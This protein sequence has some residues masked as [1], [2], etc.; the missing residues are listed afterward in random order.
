M[1]A[2]ATTLRE[3]APS[4]NITV[5]RPSTDSS[6]SLTVKLTNSH[7][8]R[9]TMPSELTIPS[10][11]LSV[12]FSVTAID[13]EILELPT[14]VRIVAEST[15]PDLSSGAIELTVLDNDSQ[16]HNYAL[17]LDVDHDNNISPLDVI[18]II[19]Y[20]NS[21]QNPSLATVTA[22]N[23]RSYIDV[24]E[25]LF[26]SPLDVIIVINYLNRRS[27][28]EGE[29][30]TEGTFAEEVNRSVLDS[31]QIEFW[32][33]S[34]IL[35][36]RSSA[37]SYSASRYSYSYS[38]TPGSIQVD[39]LFSEAVTPLFGPF[40]NEIPILLFEYEYRFT[41]Y[42]YEYEYE[43]NHRYEL[44]ATIMPDGPVLETT[45]FCRTKKIRPSRS[46]ASSG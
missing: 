12:Q 40:V 9:V 42:D 20:L 1:H 22:P 4:L 41:Q 25:D 39:H 16:W 43:K 45:C 44:L 2:P 46:D 18:T 10:G 30:A 17:P 24:D 13:N 11:Q 19:N 5:Q 36:G 14:L 38:K 29:S 27:N 28:G 31:D 6:Q 15:L 23:P 37:F 8:N 21:N 32:G 33:P 35:V 7:P 26:A 34:G 3:G